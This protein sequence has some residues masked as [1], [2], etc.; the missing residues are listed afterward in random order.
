MTPLE[1]YQQAER[2][3]TS[4][5]VAEPYRLHVVADL[6]RPDMLSGSNKIGRACLDLFA[7]KHGY[8][9]TAVAQACGKPVAEVEA[10]ASRHDDTP[11]EMAAENFATAFG[12][13]VEAEIAAAVPGW[14]EQGYDAER[15]KTES[16]QIRPKKTG[17]PPSASALKPPTG[18]KSRRAWSSRPLLRFAATSARMT[19]TN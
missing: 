9:V 12:Q 3:V 6:L 17:A 2:V 13:L 8:T 18:A 7:V 15:I 5:L 4:R 14:I 1:R 16:E 11:L 19:T 10:L